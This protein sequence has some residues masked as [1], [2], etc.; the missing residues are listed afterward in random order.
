MLSVAF[1]DAKVMLMPDGASR[2]SCL[3][4]CLSISYLLNWPAKR[5]GQAK[6]PALLHAS[7][8]TGLPSPPVPLVPRDRGARTAR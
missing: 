1:F 8:I 6:R 7:G 4:R 2:R 3:T 5:S